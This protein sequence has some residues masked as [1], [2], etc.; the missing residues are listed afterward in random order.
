MIVP[1]GAIEQHGPHLPLS[2]DWI[3]ADEVA[4]AVVERV[5]SE[6][7][8]WLLPDHAVLQ[9]ERTRLVVGNNLAVARHD[10]ASTR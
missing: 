1:I 8:V 10:D 9:V 6:L 5:G 3:I 4:Q 7:P 2:V